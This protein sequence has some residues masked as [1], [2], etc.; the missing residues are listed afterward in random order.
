M[1]EFSPDREI[2]DSRPDDG[3]FDK[4]GSLREDGWHAKGVPGTGYID[5]DSLAERPAAGSGQAVFK[6]VGRAYEWH[7]DTES[8]KMATKPVPGGSDSKILAYQ[9]S[10]RNEGGL[11]DGEYLDKPSNS[12]L[13]WQYIYSGSDSMQIST[14]TPNVFIRGGSGTD[15]IQ[16]KSG[17]NILDGGEGSNWL[18]GGD[19]QDTFFLDQRGGGVTWSTVGGYGAGDAVTIWGFNPGVSRYWWEANAGAANGKGATLRV[20]TGNTGK[21]DASV[22]FAGLSADQASKLLLTTGTQPAGSYL[23]VYNPGV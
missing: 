4:K 22:T 11:L 1:S 6:P 18:I 17:R 8:W 3:P 12:Y 21:I 14:S 19:G 16:V 15:A 9:N 7:E 2:E 13:E 20:D 23:Y 10:T 5:S